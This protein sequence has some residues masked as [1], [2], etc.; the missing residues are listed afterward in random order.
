MPHHLDVQL[1]NRHVRALGLGELLD[2]RPHLLTPHTLLMGMTTSQG[3]YL[4][5]LSGVRKRDA[6]L[7][8][9][10]LLLTLAGHGLAVPRLVGRTGIKNQPLRQWL[11]LPVRRDVQLAVYFAVPGHQVPDF[12]LD[13]GHARQAGHYLGAIHRVGR[14]VAQHHVAGAQ[15]PAW[16]RLSVFCKAHRPQNAALHQD[17]DRIT[18]GLT[19]YRV[20]RNLPRGLVYGGLAPDQ[21]H[22]KGGILSSA[23]DFGGVTRGA[24][25]QDLAQTLYRW[26]F[27]HDAPVLPRLRA[28]AQA[29]S[30]K[31][32]LD[33]SEV[34]ALWPA[35]CQTAVTSAL[36]QFSRFEL[37]DYPEHLFAP[38]P[39]ARRKMPYADY[40]HDLTRLSALEKLGAEGL[41][42]TLGL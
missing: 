9:E 31:R 16:G 19:R 32:R 5:R 13:E 14:Q 34:A 36:H 10:A 7:C 21:V 24:L 28:L 42:Q 2:A 6:L 17:L 20:P 12:L 29:Y 4:A 39:F 27:V 33:P 18:V 40:R 15:M 1:V 3:H 22:F 25:V 37:T 35:M 23:L 8:E 11:D 41:Q 26:G 30:A 38:S